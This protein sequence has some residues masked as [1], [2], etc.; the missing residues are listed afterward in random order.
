MSAALA[1]R[2]SRCLTCGEVIAQVN[3]APWVHTDGLPWSYYGLRGC[4][5]ASFDRLGTWDDSLPGNA[6]AEPASKAG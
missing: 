3:D 4:R 6:Y 1:V 2:W 5:A